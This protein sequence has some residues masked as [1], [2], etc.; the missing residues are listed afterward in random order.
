MPCARAAHP[1]AHLSQ[2][3]KQHQQQQQ[4]GNYKIQLKQKETSKFFE[5]ARLLQRTEAKTQQ[6]QKTNKQSLKNTKRMKKQMQKKN[7]IRET[8]QKIRK[9]KATVESIIIRDR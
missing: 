9:L 3:E 5:I 6:Q 7:K 8:K 2:T 4:L 1:V